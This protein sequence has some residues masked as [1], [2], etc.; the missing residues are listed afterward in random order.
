MAT[1]TSSTAQNG[2]ALQD[3]AV[4]AAIAIPAHIVQAKGHGHAGTAMALA[5]FSHVLFSRVMRH[6]PAHPD[7]VARDRFVLSAGHASLLLYVQLFLTG[8]GLSLDDIAASRKLGSLTP[9]H[10]EHGHTVG[11]EMS[12]GPLGQ[13]VASAVGMAI[14]A[15]K[16]A[17]EFTPGSDI[18]DHTIWAVAGDGCL[19]EGVSGEA[20]SLAGTLGLDNLVLVWDD[21]SI[22]IDGNTSEAFREDVRARYRAYGWRVLDIHDHTDLGEI[23]RV[24]REA[25]DR[26]TADGRPTLVAL[27]SVIAAPSRK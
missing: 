25:A 14:A 24:L 10:P 15:R 1:E 12:T 19:Q 16:E 2:P 21:N 6:N 11:V 5:P 3:R 27:T 18:L 22:T 9:G 4:A 23:E 17:A 7:W 26:S 20:S 8:Y 13:G